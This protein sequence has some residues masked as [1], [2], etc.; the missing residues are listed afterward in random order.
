VGCGDGKYFPAIW[1]AGS[2]VIGTDISLPL[3]QMSVGASVESSAPE[4]RQVS[5]HRTQLRD[6]PAVAV[7]DCIHVPLRDNSMDAAICVAVLHHL[8][9]QDR[10]LRCLQ[11]LARIVKPGGLINVQAWA[12]DQEETSRRKFASTD[13]FVPFNAQPKYLEKAIQQRASTSDKN[14]SIA[15]VFA[16]AYEGAEYDER[17][18]LVV[19]KR[20]CHLY[21]QG[22][23]EDLAS[24]VEGVRLVE[25]GFE[26]G[27]YYVILQ[28]I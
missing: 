4:N 14:Q 12:M 9:T 27:N 23:M 21:R 1:E 16:E 15:E 8:S 11:E 22:E 25:S 7:A 18:G 10:R 28:K 2:Y 5:H 13:V 24:R 26:S 20:Y 17:K 3:L 6:R 19:F